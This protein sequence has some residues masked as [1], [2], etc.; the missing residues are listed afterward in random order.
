ME[1][2]YLAGCK[3]GIQKMAGWAVIIILCIIGTGLILV[4][5]VVIK[6][7][8]EVLSMEKI[9]EQSNTKECEQK[10]QI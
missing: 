1:K 2:I 5:F 6:D 4:C 8:D 3:G 9:D 10:K 7:L